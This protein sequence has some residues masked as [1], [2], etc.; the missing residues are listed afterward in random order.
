SSRVFTVNSGTTAGCPNGGSVSAIDTASLVVVSTTCVGLFPSAIAQLPN[1]GKLYVVFGDAISVLD[2]SG[3]T[4]LST[5]GTSIVDPWSP[6]AV[7]SSVD[8]SYVFVL[9]RTRLFGRPHYGGVW[10]ITTSN[11]MVASVVG[12]GYPDFSVLDTHLNR[13]YVT[14]N[15]LN[16]VSVFDAASVNVANNPAM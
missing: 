10:I 3:S 16:T 14:D 6:E 2:P 4:V 11:D 15:G 1:G 8:G 9:D 7:T 12:G 5:I 13:L